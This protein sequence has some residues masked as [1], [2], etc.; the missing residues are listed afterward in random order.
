MPPYTASYSTV[1]WFLPEL[2]FGH[3]PLSTT[4]D[5]RGG[6][7]HLFLPYAFMAWTGTT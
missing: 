4:E 7:V 1:T 2:G 6:A 3:S 5:K